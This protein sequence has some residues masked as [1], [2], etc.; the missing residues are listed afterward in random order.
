MANLCTG[1]RYKVARLS[2]GIRAFQ[3]LQHHPRFIK[4]AARLKMSATITPNT[5]TAADGETF[6]PSFPD[7]PASSN[8]RP[9][10]QVSYGLPFDQACV[11][12]VK[13]FINAQRV[14]IIASQSLASGTDNFKR[15]ETALGD[16]HAGTQIGIPAHTPMDSLVPIMQDMIEKKADCLITLGGGSLA[17]GAKAIVYVRL[18]LTPSSTPI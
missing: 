13:G 18:S 8:E 16:R 3:Q 10:T 15:L 11:K 12:H 14:Y 4:T 6:R 17:D 7:I 5:N 2:M 9:Y 1:G